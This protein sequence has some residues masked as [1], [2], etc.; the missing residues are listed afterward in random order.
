MEELRFV[1]QGSRPEPCEVR[2]IRRDDGNLLAFCSCAAGVGGRYCVHRFKLMAGDAEGVISSNVE[3]VALL[4]Q[5]LEGT[6]VMQALERLAAAEARMAE[7]KRQ[8]AVAKQALA[9]ATKG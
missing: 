5:W 8:V 7:A 9:A 2:F 1:V 6:N 4:P 3:E